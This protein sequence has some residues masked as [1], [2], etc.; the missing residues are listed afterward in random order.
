MTDAKARIGEAISLKATFS[1][2]V[3]S[4]EVAGSEEPRER[5]GGTGSG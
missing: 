2:E 1:T 3:S 5:G 4:G